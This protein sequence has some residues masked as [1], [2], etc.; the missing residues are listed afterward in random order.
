MYKD[1]LVSSG[2]S[3]NE[4]II[5]EYLLKKG[6]VSAGEIIKNTP[7]KRGLTYNELKNL[8]KKS[9]IR[10]T[11]KHKIAFFGPE[12]PN[13][14][15]ELTEN[16]ENE[17]KKAKNTL[18]NQFSTILSNFNLVSNQPGIIY[19]EGIIGLEKVYE[20]IIKAKEDI[21][22][23][24]SI[25]D[26]K[27]FAIDRLVKKQI[28][29]Q[30][31]N[32]IHTRAITPL[33]DNMS[34]VVVSQDTQN[35]VERRIVPKDKFSLPAQIIIFQN[36]VA[37]TSL[38]KNIFTTIIENDSIA[39]SFKIIFNFIWELSTPIHEKIYQKINTKK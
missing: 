8:L 35:L 2:L 33:M 7:L 15:I 20:E 3:A 17:L 18:E 32:N 37:I 31:K 16:R 22:I 13:K 25:A 6:E 23:F 5:Y 27:Q 26:D 38:D 12:H 28:S 10:K 11:L 24:R 19:L 36:K 1:I 29:R 21:L 34:F 14:L 9:L 39:L 4:A 30:V